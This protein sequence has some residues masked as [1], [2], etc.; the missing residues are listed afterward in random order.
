LTTPSSLL[1]LISG[2]QKHPNPKTAISI[3]Y[4]LI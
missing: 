2:P 1:N 3:D 4:S